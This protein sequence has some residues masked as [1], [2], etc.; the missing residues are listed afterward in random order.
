MCMLWAPC[1]GTLDAFLKHALA[2]P[3]QAELFRLEGLFHV[4]LGDGDAADRAFSTSLTLWPQLAAAWLSWGEFCDSKVG[5]YPP[6]LDLHLM[7]LFGKLQLQ[8]GSFWAW[9]CLQC[10]CTH[11]RPPG[12]CLQ[13]HAHIPVAHCLSHLAVSASHDVVGA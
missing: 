10:G 11:A 8:V 4:A 5:S 2:A 13:V 6:R 9:P 3:A 12:T 1:K 7:N